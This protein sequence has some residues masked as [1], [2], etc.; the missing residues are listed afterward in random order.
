MAD[1]RKSQMG[2]TDKTTAAATEHAALAYGLKTGKCFAESTLKDSNIQMRLRG[3]VEHVDT[4]E[5][6]V[7]SKTNEMLTRVF[8]G[9]PLFGFELTH[10]LYAADKERLCR[11]VLWRCFQSVSECGLRELLYHISKNDWTQRLLSLGVPLLLLDGC[12]SSSAVVK[13][14]AV[15][16]GFVELMQAIVETNMG[17]IWQ[18]MRNKHAYLGDCPAVIVALTL[19]G[20][21]MS[22]TKKLRLLTWWNIH[23]SPHID[24]ALKFSQSPSTPGI[25]R[26]W[27]KSLLLI[28]DVKCMIENGNMREPFNI[29]CALNRTG[30]YGVYCSSLKCSVLVDKDGLLPHCGRCMLARYCSRQCQRDH[31]KQGHK[32]QCWKRDP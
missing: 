3:H 30:Q 13:R 12:S 29:I 24:T 10:M 16:P 26:L 25:F 9:E 18:E 5:Y 11:N 27:C 23:V 4:N 17:T 2:S 20:K 31:W 22:F 28:N 15:Y 7:L 21:C 8:T 19:V 6:D 14:I 1:K 32:E